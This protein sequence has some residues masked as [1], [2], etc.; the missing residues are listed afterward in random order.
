MSRCDVLDI[1]MMVIKL[2]SSI[3]YFKPDVLKV[4]K[5]S[6]DILISKCVH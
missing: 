1:M 5:T 6:I 3:L 4:L 2:F